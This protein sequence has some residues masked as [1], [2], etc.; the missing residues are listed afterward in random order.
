MT[1]PCI[2]RILC[3]TAAMAAATPLSAQSMRNAP[4]APFDP[5]SSAGQ[6]RTGASL[7]LSAVLEGDGGRIESDLSWRIYSDPADGTSAQLVARSD[8]PAPVFSLEPGA[9]VV[10]VTFGLAGMTRRVVLAQQPQTERIGIPAGGLVLRAQIGD[11]P[12]PPEKL[13]FNVFVPVGADPEGRLV[14][15]NVAAGALLRLPEGQYRVVSS[16]GNSNAISTADLRV[17]SGKILEATLRH[18]AATVTLKLVLQPGAE[19]LAGTTFSVLTPGGDTVRE[20]AGAFPTMIL[21]EGEY[22]VIA[23]HGGK[24]YTNEVKVRSGFDRDIEVIAR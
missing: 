6:G 13:R 3:L 11:S 2:V 19:A 7:S 9:Y 14:A 1:R 12:V 21:A 18:R 17:D 15:A 5:G 4:L 10:H 24:V 22:V 23:R 8:L 20:A 16:Y